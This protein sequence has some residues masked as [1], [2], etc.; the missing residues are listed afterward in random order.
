MVIRAAGFLVSA[1]YLTTEEAGM[2]QHE[3][4]TALEGRKTEPGVVEKALSTKNKPTIDDVVHAI[5]GNAP[6]SF[7]IPGYPPKAAMAYWFVDGIDKAGIQLGLEAWK[8]LSIWAS[9]EFERQLSY[10]VSG[11]DALMDPA[12]LA[13]ATSLVM[14]LRKICGKIGFLSDVSKGLPSTFELMHAVQ[15]VFAT[16]TESGIWNKAFPLFHFPGSGAADYCFSFEFLEAI[17]IEFSELNLLADPYILDRISKAVTWCARHRLRFRQGERDYYGWNAG[18]EVTNLAAGVPE[19]WATGAVHMFLW[20]LDSSISNWLQKLIL[21]RRFSRA[22]TPLVKKWETLIDVDMVFPGDEKPSLKQVLE[23]EL[24]RPAALAKANEESLR[25]RPLKSRR[26]A[27]LFGPPGTSKTT[28]AKGIA[29]ELTWPLLVITPSDFLSLGL[30]QIYVRATEIF[31]DLMDLS[32]VV[33]LFDEM[34]ALAQT[35][36]NAALDVTRQLLTTSMLPK[37]ADLHDLGRVIFLMATNHKKDLDPA[38]TRPGRFDLLLCVG[39]PSWT[40]KIEGMKEVL[41][42]LPAGDVAEVQKNLKEFSDSV[43]TKEQLDLFTVADLRSFLEHVRRRERAETL[44]QAL[45]KIDRDTF[46]HDVSI[47]AKS[48]ITLSEADTRLP[49]T[50][51]DLRTE[52]DRDKQASRIQ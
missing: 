20:E 21:E 42:D 18:G 26:S 15:Q 13:M 44:S 49:E 48:Y 52:Y 51:L 12:S 31:Q 39:P 1:G 41:K 30:E 35:R 43:A 11:N 5:A 27:L 4:A 17:L 50:D 36:G 8:K 19:A 46:Q 40:N 45:G 9:G 25:R 16:Q 14:R 47:W 37:L 32:G 29:G 2:L 38:I 10:V 23:T 24:I 3:K 34:D 28:V 33:I 22:E 7:S 6:E